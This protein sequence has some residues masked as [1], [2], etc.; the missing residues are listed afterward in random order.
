MKTHPLTKIQGSLAILWGILNIVVLRA[1]DRVQEIWLLIS[2]VS[3]LA[4]S[5]VTFW[6]GWLM[7]VRKEVIIYPHEGYLIRR[8]R[9][10]NKQKRAYQI[11]KN[12]ESESRRIAFGI[13]NM[14]SGIIC[15]VIGIVGV[16][17]TIQ[18][19]N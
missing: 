17:I 15:V 6:I 7:I 5:M 13:M 10:R 18:S 11:Q 9:K 4:L 12:T 1:E 3:F 19:W 2:I 16:I 8:A 14:F